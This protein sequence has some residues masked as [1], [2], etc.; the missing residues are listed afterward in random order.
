MATKELAMHEKLEVHEIL[1]MKTAC[2]T[3]SKATLDL[4]KD[5]KLKKLV[6]EDIKLSSAAIKELKGILEKV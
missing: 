3:K 1:I 5:E 4:I 6:E 2:A